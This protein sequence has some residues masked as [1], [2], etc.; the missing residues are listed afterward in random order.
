M[1]LNGFHALCCEVD[2]YAQIP[3]EY[4]CENKFSICI[5]ILPDVLE[6]QGTL[7]SIGSILFVKLDNKRIRLTGEG[8]Q[9]LSDE[10]MLLRRCQNT[11]I[12]V[13]DGK[14]ISVY[15]N[16]ALA[17]QKEISLRPIN[18]VD[19]RI[20]ENLSTV[21]I[22]KV[23]IF[24]D[25]LE[26]QVIQSSTVA[27]LSGYQ[28]QI[29][30]AMPV[31]SSDVTLHQC[32]IKDCVYTLDCTHG[33][34]TMPCV[35]L[36]QE[37]TLMFSFYAFNHEYGGGIL[38]KSPRMCIK[39]NDRYGLG[40]P[41]FS[42]EYDG[43]THN[44]PYFIKTN[45]W[46]NL[47]VVFGNSWIE[48]YFDGEIF[49]KTQ[50]NPSSEAGDLEFGKFDGYL[51]S[52]AII[53]SALTQ[54]EISD[55]LNQPPDVFDKD[56]LY[57]FNFYDKLLRESCHGTVMTP[58]G[59]EIILA[60]GTGAGTREDKSKHI[61]QSHRTYSE[62]VIW[63]INLLLHLLV[64]WIY[65]QLKV[66]PNKGVDTTCEPWKIDADLQQFVYEE[67]LP[68][69]EAQILLSHYDNLDS[70][71][72]RNLIQ[73]ME[74][75]GT[76]KK[77]M[78]YLYQEDD[79][80]D[81]ISD[82]LM[83]LL[84]AIA[85][86]ALMAAL[87]KAI[88]NMPPIPKP[89]NPSLNDFD[90]DDD[91]EDDD[92]DD[93]K[94]KKTYASIEKTV[95]KGDMQIDF[96]QKGISQ[97]I[98]RTAVFFGNSNSQSTGLEVSLSYKGD[99]GEFTVF[100]EN[101]NSKVLP[102]SQQNVS[103]QGNKSVK[104]SLAV[105]PKEFGKK[106]GKCTETLRWRCES[107]DGEQAQFLGETNYVFY[108]LE[109]TPCKLWN[110]TVHI[111]CLELCADCAKYIGDNSEGFVKDYAQFMQNN[112]AK[113]EHDADS[114]LEA[115][116]SAGSYRES[117]SK[118]PVP[119]NN[120]FVFD[121][122]N[123]AR[124]YRRG[125]RNIS[126]NDMVYSNVIFAYLNG[127][128]VIKALWLSTNISYRSNNGQ[129]ISTYLLLRDS[130]HG[131]DFTCLEDSMHYVMMYDN[132]RIVDPKRNSYDLPFSDNKEREVTGMYNSQYYRESQY[133][134]GSYC[135]II[136]SID[137][138][139]W[140]LGDL[141]TNQLSAAGLSEI[142]NLPENPAVA[143]VTP[144]GGGGYEHNGRTDSDPSVWSY[145][146]ERDREKAREKTRG[147]AINFDAV[148]HS[149]SSYDID[150][151]I[152]GICTNAPQNNHHVHLQYLV[153]AL[154]PQTVGEDDFTNNYH[155]LA[156]HA[157]NTLSRCLMQRNNYTDNVIAHFC[158][159]T[160]NSPGNL[161]LGNGRWNGVIRE[162]FDP[163]SW[164]YYYAPDAERI[165]S[166]YGIDEKRNGELRGILYERYGDIPDLLNPGFYLPNR[167]DGIRI[168]NL[169][170][171]HHPVNIICK[172]IRDVGLGFCPFIC[173]SSNLF[174]YGGNGDRYD[175]VLGNDI[176]R[177]YFLSTDDRWVLLH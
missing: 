166:D 47:T 53:K 150:Q 106:Y 22:R 137:S 10:V 173:S 108:F 110:D 154:Y 21:C 134:P 11:V 176:P 170:D 57:L 129:Y 103:F 164:F 52:C 124:D 60:K 143:W 4:P 54:K 18:P 83:G 130:V 100:A 102:S 101:T 168:R 84:G 61:P 128:N 82:I 169:L 73:A 144:R 43:Q 94:K 118:I 28:K 6:V 139:H 160:A 25:Q 145:I 55:Y 48:F 133:L 74:Q 177:I 65:E 42:I 15:C 39:L 71:E 175:A 2:G 44:S 37:Y 142:N 76:L 33:K 104:I 135:E 111:E 149:I 132:D 8:F 161:R 131:N 155:R 31:T 29:D 158:R 96:E 70:Q 79:N 97:D 156:E 171:I 90:F 45:Q 24:H 113:N 140:T 14:K 136:R 81:S 109:N 125:V 16:G 26:E 64:N 123:F 99:D 152:A 141:S 172:Q 36:P 13:Y 67:I 88:T 148:C 19:L 20:G 59:S 50:N 5:Q 3:W 163:Q 93:E 122:V 38:L 51:D 41:G 23:I 157:K 98:E 146:R 77:L 63:Q 46:V 75:N 92:E 69:K 58:S 105:H 159:L 9:Y 17:I 34:L 138:E 91:D 66:Y 95:L 119:G 87:G 1:N 78:D 165:I 40:S 32:D 86:A 121:A 27:K 56:V 107:S 30:F 62:F 12:A 127:C 117:Y 120:K 112:N 68:M 115:G 85:L 153:N 49:F 116:T 151:I 126:Y 80:Q 7:F 174:E 114:V 35:H 147:R 72:L 89:P 162:A 167:E